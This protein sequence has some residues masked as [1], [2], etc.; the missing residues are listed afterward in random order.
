MNDTVGVSNLP[1]QRVEN[2]YRRTR[3]GV[4]L[5]YVYDNS[6]KNPRNP[7]HP[8][9]RVRWGEQTTDEMAIAFLAVTLPPLEVQSFQQ[10]IAFQYVESLLR[11]GATLDDLP[12]EL[13]PQQRQSLTLAFNLFDTNHDG[14]LDAEE[15]AALIQFLC[16]R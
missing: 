15:S 7:V 3:D 14:K 5:E 13:S 8:P 1:S 10:E 2:I 12:P 9:V 11:Q 6:E 4:D 16:R